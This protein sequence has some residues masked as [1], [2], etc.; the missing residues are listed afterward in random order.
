MVPCALSY[1]SDAGAARICQQG[2]GQSERG[3]EATERG[4]G[5]GGGFP[6]PR[7]LGRIL[8]MCV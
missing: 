7:Y 1:A 3:S 4:E 5:V 8:N 6:L 2:G